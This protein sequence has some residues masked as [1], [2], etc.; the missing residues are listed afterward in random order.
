LKNYNGAIEL[1][2]T[3]SQ[4]DA[5][6]NAASTESA[7]TKATETLANEPLDDEIPF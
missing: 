6:D 3:K 4:S 7:T 2:D 5:T 1:L